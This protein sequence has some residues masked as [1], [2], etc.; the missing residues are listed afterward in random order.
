MRQQLLT[1]V[2]QGPLREAVAVLS[3]LPMLQLL[4]G[5]PGVRMS[6]VY[7]VWRLYDEVGKE[8]DSFYWSFGSSPL[9]NMPGA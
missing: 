6:L 5:M 2:H 1:L 4:P 7:L 3:K 8:L 9:V